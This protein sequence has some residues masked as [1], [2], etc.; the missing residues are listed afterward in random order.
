MSSDDLNLALDREV[1]LVGGGPSTGKSLSIVRLALTG[2]EEGFNVVVIDRDRG[3]S[4]AV[5]EL[6]KLG[7][8][9]GVPD[10]MD[11]FIAK[12]W[13]RVT[14]GMDHA[15]SNLEAGD[16]LCFDM[17]G[18][19]WDLAQDEFT[20]MVYKE[21]ST[22][23]ILALR[24]EAEEVVRSHGGKDAA[25]DRAKGVGFEGLEG[26]YDWPLIKKMHNGDVRDHAIL[27]GDFNIFSTTTMT[28]LDSSRQ[29][30]KE[31]WP[32][33]A[34]LGRR[35]EGE[36]NNV[37]KHDTFLLAAQNDGKYTWSSALGDHQGKDRGRELVRGVS[38]TGQ[39]IV[40][41]YL[42][43]HAEEDEEDGS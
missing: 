33:F 11:Y 36:K 43:Y 19:L 38:Y 20:R 41:S 8:I 23:K 37:H 21:G 40:E 6:I 18:A 16:W 15:F 22:E 27:D 2:L 24:M 32:M 34:A 42:E 14:E 29:G 10:N 28:P 9:S 39:G 26:R 3:V 4:K 25:K 13:D 35:P 7:E 30:E 1:I 5:K 17:I 12:T 31:K